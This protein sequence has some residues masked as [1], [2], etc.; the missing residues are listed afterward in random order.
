MRS[1]PFGTAFPL[2]KVWAMLRTPRPILEA[3]LSPAERAIALSLFVE[4]NRSVLVEL[5]ALRCEV[6]KGLS[7]KRKGQVSGV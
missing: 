1:V 4:V 2:E 6:P 7:G 3:K 5:L